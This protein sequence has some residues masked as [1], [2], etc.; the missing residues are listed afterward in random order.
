[1]HY[2]ET[3]ESFTAQMVHF[4]SDFGVNI[5]GGCCGTTPAHLRLVVE[6]MQQITPK[7]RNA[8]TRAGSFV[9]LHVNSLTCRMRRS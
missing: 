2:D 7:Q 5:V 8:K 3:P 1:M 4:A 9:D 6:A